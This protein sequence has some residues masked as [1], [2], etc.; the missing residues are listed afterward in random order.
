MSLANDKIMA[1]LIVI[2]LALSMSI[3]KCKWCLI[4][5][6]NPFYE[7]RCIVNKAYEISSIWISWL[8]YHNM[9]I[10][11]SRSD[12]TLVMTSKWQ[13][14]SGYHNIETCQNRNDTVLVM[15]LKWQV[16]RNSHRKSPNE[17]AL[18]IIPFWQLFVGGYIL[19]YVHKY[20]LDLWD[21]TNLSNRFAPWIALLHGL[22]I[23]SKKL[24]V[25]SN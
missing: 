25:L 11:Q 18:L 7:K 1:K 6:E 17:M 8:F 12:T 14:F 5:F 15:T 23:E 24:G 22:S 10:H 13:V 3:G 4:T 19:S 16:F 2:E 20:P 21:E 9:E